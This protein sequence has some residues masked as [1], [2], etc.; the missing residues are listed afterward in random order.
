MAPIAQVR[1]DRCHG[2]VPDRPCVL[3]TSIARAST[4]KR[5]HD[6]MKVRPSRVLSTQVDARDYLRD[7]TA[8][9]AP[10]SPAR[11]TSEPRVSRGVSPRSGSRLVTVTLLKWQILLWYYKALTR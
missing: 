6:K 2:G 1:E 4:C 3:H 11:R 5:K 10:L 8:T 7:T 9:A